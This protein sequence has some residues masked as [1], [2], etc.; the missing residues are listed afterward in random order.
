M[1]SPQEN[2]PAGRLAALA[3]RSLL[4]LTAGLAALLEVVTVLLR[5]GAGLE[6]ASDPLGL[7]ALTGG[8]RL[9]HGVLG[10]LLLAAALSVW[11][12]ITLR[13]VL[14]IVGGALLLSDAA[15]HLLVLWPATGDPGFG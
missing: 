8:G 14:L 2:G 12:R 5:F 6:A 15:H 10:L 9:H 4:L 13:N 11:R 3:P 1:P 7:G